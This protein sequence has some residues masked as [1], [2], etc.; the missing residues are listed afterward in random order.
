MILILIKGESIGISI[1]ADKKEIKVGDS[2]T[3]TIHIINQG[4]DMT[5]NLILDIYMTQ[6]ISMIKG[7]IQRMRGILDIEEEY[8]GL[9]IG[10]LAPQEVAQVIF[11]ARLEEEQIVKE[12]QCYGIIRGEVTS[13]KAS[14]RVNNKK[15]E[16]T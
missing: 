1:E 9:T 3:Y 8:T 13:N 2:F 10:N 6:G 16:M 7:A 5:R 4:S 11:E 12:I 14:I 15:K